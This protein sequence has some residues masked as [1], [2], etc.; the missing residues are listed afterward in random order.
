M[1]EA[2]DPAQE[3]TAI[4]LMLREALE[5]PGQTGALVTPDRNL[6]RRVAAELGRWNIAIDDFCWT[7]AYAHTAG[8]ISVSAGGRGATR[9]CAAGVAS[10]A[11]T[12]AGG[13]R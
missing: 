13:R 3:A 11:Q 2:A 12:S 1:V 8:H 7:A 4:A 10:A 9:F 6:A 5:V